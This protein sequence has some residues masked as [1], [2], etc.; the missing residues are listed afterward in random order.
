MDERKR[1]Q[2]AV[3]LSA[4]R[5]AWAELS[6]APLDSVRAVFHYVRHDRTVPPEEL[7]DADGLARLVTEVPLAE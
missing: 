5:V 6:G 3:Q 1:R 2:L 7:L 4:Y